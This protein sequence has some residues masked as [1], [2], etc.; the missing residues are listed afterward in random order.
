MF[1]EDWFRSGPLRRNMKASEAELI[2]RL[3]RENRQYR[4]ENR[5]YEKRSAELYGRLGL[6]DDTSADRAGI[7]IEGMDRWRAII[8]NAAQSGGTGALRTGMSHSPAASP[9]ATAFR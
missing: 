9:R 6:D 3:K 5:K 7:R 8:E 4:R 1:S 2:R